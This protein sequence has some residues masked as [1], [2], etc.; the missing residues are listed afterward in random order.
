MISKDEIVTEFDDPFNVV[1]VAF[2]E[3]Q[4]QLSFYSCLIVILLL[5]LDQL[6]CHELIVLVIQ[7]LDDLAKRSFTDNF[8][9]LEP[10]R[11]VVAFLNSVIAFLVIKAIV[12]EPLQLGGFDFVFVFTHI[13]DLIEFIDFCFLEIG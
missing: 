3:K 12:D 13:I 6:D 2:L 5:I 11:D 8:Y 9:Q 10:I 1:G 7:T 4:Q